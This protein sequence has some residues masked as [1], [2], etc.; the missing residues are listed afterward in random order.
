MFAIITLTLL[1]IIAGVGLAVASAKFSVKK[2]A[3]TVEV[4]DLLPGIN[5]GACGYPGCAAMA[6]AVTAGNVLPSAC[7]V[8][9]TEAVKA[10]AVIMGIDINAGVKRVARLLCIG[11]KTVCPPVAEYDGPMDCTIME[12]LSGGGKP[13]VYGCMGGGNCASAC[14][15]NGIV[16]GDNGLPVIN[17]KRCI[18]CGL[19]A[20]ACP[21]GLIKL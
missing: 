8:S 9:S 5:C 12:S 2:D 10:I 4:L 20:K 13:C 15:Y 7:P 3:R 17:E 11:D 18:S 1:G 21:R 19:C 16:M 6:C 14:N